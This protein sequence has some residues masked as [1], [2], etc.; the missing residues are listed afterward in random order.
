MKQYTDITVLLDRSGSMETIQKDMEG[1]FNTFL[2][3]H[4]ANPS[5]RITLIQ[6][7]DRDDQ[8]VVYQNVPVT[9]ADQLTLR[10]RGWTPLF[11][12][13]CKAIDNTGKRLANIPE[14]DRPD[15][16]LMVVITDGLENKSTH[17]T[18][19]D[20]RDRVSHQKDA[21]KWQFVY[22]GANQDAIAEAATFGIDRNWAIQ[23]KPSAIGT[24][25]M[26]RALAANTVA[27][28]SN[29]ADTRGTAMTGFTK[30]QRDAAIDD[31]DDL[32][33]NIPKKKGKI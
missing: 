6:F 12:A 28:T 4:K 32:L 10:P 5:T 14:S 8:D 2:K 22:L 18:R 3:E 27:Y 17:Y 20:V 33:K 15:Q 7:D 13:F 23:Y 11:D 9:V 16:V 29:S 25:S 24:R 26:G 31:E 30:G 1:A 19:K 21:Y